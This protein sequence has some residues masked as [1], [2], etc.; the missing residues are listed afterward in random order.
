[1]QKALRNPRE[2]TGG[3]SP[4]SPHLLLLRAAAAAAFGRPRSASSGNLQGETGVHVKSVMA[5]KLSARKSGLKNPSPPSL[6]ELCFGCC[7]WPCLGKLS[8]RS[9]QRAVQAR[10]H[11]SAP[12]HHPGPVQGSAQPTQLAGRGLPFRTNPESYGAARCSPASGRTFCC[13]IRAA[14]PTCAAL[15][16]AFIAAQSSCRSALVQLQSALRTGEGER[17]PSAPRSTHESST[18][19]VSSPSCPPRLTL[20]LLPSFFVPDHLLSP[21]C[22]CFEAALGSPCES[23]C[24]WDA[25]LP[26][27][28]FPELLG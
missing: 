11:S 28:A 20:V 16:P 5:T 27:P 3:V 17:S 15:C 6:N 4:T 18:R 9:Q 23:F 22:H 19:L 7:F 13:F 10:S 8:S 25:F 24:C 2:P 12:L 26:P 14:F 1:M 21:S